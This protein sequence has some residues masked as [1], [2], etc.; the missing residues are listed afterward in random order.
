[1]GDNET[2]KIK[3]VIYKKLFTR[4]QLEIYH[5]IT[6]K[7]I[8]EDANCTS[9]LSSFIGDQ[10]GNGVFWK[11]SDRLKKYS[12]RRANDYWEGVRIIVID[13]DTPLTD[14]KRI[15]DEMEQDFEHVVDTIN[16][17]NLCK[18]ILFP[19]KVDFSVFRIAIQTGFGGVLN[20][21]A[22]IYVRPLILGDPPLV[23]VDALDRLIDGF[24]D[25][26]LTGQ[27]YYLSFEE[28]L[29]PQ[30]E[31]I[32]NQIIDKVKTAY[33]KIEEYRLLDSIEKEVTL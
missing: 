10:N 28:D 19:R 12:W 14:Q 26:R 22:E 15:F 24:H 7:P 32:F 20:G 23:L 33:V 1:M 30:L 4:D 25:F 31:E 13:V 2:L 29:S 16:R 11:L 3:S 27:K 17:W 5:H 21:K 18:Y 9:F 8:K 6:I